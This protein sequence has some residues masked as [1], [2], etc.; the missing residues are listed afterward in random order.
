MITEPP[1]MIRLH[2]NNF[3]LY[4]REDTWRCENLS[5]IEEFL[6]KF[7]FDEH[8]KQLRLCQESV[9]SSLAWDLLE[10]ASD[11]GSTR[12]AARLFDK[13]D[14]VHGPMKHDMSMRITSIRYDWRYA[15]LRTI[16]KA[17]E[18]RG[19]KAR[20]RQ[21]HWGS[22]FFLQE[23]EVS[24]ANSKPDRPPVSRGNTKASRNKRRIGA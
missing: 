17:G 13:D 3:V 2:P 19:R 1:S 14:V 4:G 8:R 16:L 11:F 9:S 21:A 10:L 24:K 18:R 15:I 6:D 22:Q 23:L 7:Q 12:M 5:E 20:A